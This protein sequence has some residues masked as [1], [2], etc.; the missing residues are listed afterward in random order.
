MSNLEIINTTT[1]KFHDEL[2]EEIFYRMIKDSVFNSED[3]C[4]LKLANSEEVKEYN[5]KYRGKNANTDVLSFPC[6]IPN[7]P[8]K[9]DIVIDVDTANNQKL[10]KPLEKEIGELFIHGLL[11]LAGMDHLSKKEKQQMQLF[12]L[13]YNIILEEYFKN[14]G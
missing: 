3:K 1:E 6:Q 10:N 11:H 9:G 4:C 13:K 7:I 14:R 8:F 2:F 5:Q 12:E